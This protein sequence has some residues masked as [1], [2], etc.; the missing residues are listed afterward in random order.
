MEA[1]EKARQRTEEGQNSRKQQ[2]VADGRQSLFQE[3]QACEYSGV[4]LMGLSPR[5]SFCT[6]SS[7]RMLMHGKL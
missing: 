6:P 4:A 2:W 3:F 5:P 7:C 1:G